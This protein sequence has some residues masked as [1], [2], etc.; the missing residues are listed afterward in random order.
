MTIDIGVNIGNLP[1]TKKI[2]DKINK[3]QSETQEVFQE[4]AQGVGERMIDRTP[5][6]TGRA[7]GNWQTKLNETPTESLLRYDKEGVE[8]KEELREVTSKATV[9]DKITISNCVTY[10]ENLEYG[11]S[12]QAPEGMVRITVAEADEIFQ[13]AVN[14]VK[15][16]NR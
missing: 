14:K 3:I 9:D 13:S 16:K 15:A 4:F 12:K 5:V 2:L 10:T 1:V 11:S 7:K 6:D 8:A